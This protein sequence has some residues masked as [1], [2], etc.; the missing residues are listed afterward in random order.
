M[1]E[2]FN[3]W[4]V[5][6][7]RFAEFEK[8]ERSCGNGRKRAHQLI[9]KANEDYQK[10]LKNTKKREMILLTLKNRTL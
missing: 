9:T 2:D 1:K 6:W 10:Y 8:A 5:K 4:F 7:P 3:T